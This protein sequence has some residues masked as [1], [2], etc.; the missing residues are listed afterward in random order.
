MKKEFV[1]IKWWFLTLIC[2]YYVDL[3][4]KYNKLWLFYFNMYNVYIVMAQNYIICTFYVTLIHLWRAEKIGF[5]SYFVW[6]CN[7]DCNCDCEDSIIESVT[8]VKWAV[9]Y[10]YLE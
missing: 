9:Y 4:I 6:D 7:C 10:G 2:I 1:I 5:V 8:C 3:A